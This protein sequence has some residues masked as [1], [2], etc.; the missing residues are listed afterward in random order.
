MEAK[1]IRL[2]IAMQKTKLRQLLK[3]DKA[4]EEY[5]VTEKDSCYIKARVGAFVMHDIEKSAMRL[6]GLM[7]E[8]R[9]VE[10]YKEPEEFINEDAE[11]ITADKLPF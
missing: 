9:T 10:E 11:E 8:L 4:L 3:F 1:E 7:D 2:R 6:I 5:F